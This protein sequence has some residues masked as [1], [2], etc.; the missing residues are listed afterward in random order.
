MYATRVTLCIERVALLGV[1]R[2]HAESGSFGRVECWFLA[3][4]SSSA[5]SSVR[6]LPLLRTFYSDLGGGTG[7]ERRVTG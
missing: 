2:C 3:W 4:P 6:V 1:G 5:E 7:K